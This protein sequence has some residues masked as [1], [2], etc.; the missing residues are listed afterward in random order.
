ME[1]KVIH[2]V[3]RIRDISNPMMMQQ[4]SIQWSQQQQMG[5]R[6]GS[7]MTSGGKPM[8]YGQQRMPYNVDPYMMRQSTPQSSASPSPSSYPYPTSNLGKF[9]LLQSLCHLFDCF[10]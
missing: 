1:E 9:L 10:F 8:A 7:P 6:Y 5:P 4:Q 2:Q 3:H